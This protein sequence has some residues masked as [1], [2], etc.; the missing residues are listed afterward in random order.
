ME[1]NMKAKKLMLSAAIAGALGLGAAAPALADVYAGSS[2]PVSA[3]QITF[4]DAGDTDI[5]A[6]DAVDITSFTFTTSADA[7]VNQGATELGSDSSS[8]ACDQGSCTVGPPVLATG[9]VNATNTG[10]QRTSGA[11]EYEFIGN[12]QDNATAN[13]TSYANS[14]AEITSA[15]LVSGVPT[16]TQAIAESNL[17]ASESATNANAGTN[18]NSQTTFTLNFTLAEDITGP[19]TM[20]IAFDATPMLYAS[21]YG[22]GGNATASQS[23]SFT[24]DQVV[25]G[26]TVDT[27]VYSP[28]G[29]DGCAPGSSVGCT[30]DTD[31]YNLQRGATA[32]PNFDT[33]GSYVPG[34]GSWLVTFSNLTAGN[35]SLNLNQTNS[36]TTFIRPTVPE[37]A[38]LALLATGL[39]AGGLSRKALRK[40]PSRG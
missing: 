24:L 30:D 16:E 33:S 21:V 39:L 5:S 32:G 28:N 2:T 9:P 36:V 31:P 40:R 3:L 4:Y 18:I 37:P 23:L 15:E 13:G 8:P 10:S 34:T 19:A 35:Y 11:T 25:D 22:T 20:T 27:A 12:Y 14:A 38:T 17:T 7:T 26:E 29:N 1:T 6:T